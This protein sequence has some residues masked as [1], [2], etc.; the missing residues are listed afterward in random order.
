MT[1]S[2]P[3]PAADG[4]AADPSVAGPARDQYQVQV[5][6]GEGGWEVRVVESAAPDLGA[7]VYTRACEGE[8]EARTFGSTV[9]QHLHWLSATKFGEYYRLGSP[10][11]G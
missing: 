10:P 7:V 3:V 5:E 4:E 1:T 11:E 8:A 6:R 9:N 2:V